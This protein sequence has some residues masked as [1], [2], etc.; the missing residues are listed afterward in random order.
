MKFYVNE[1]LYDA[2][3]PRRGRWDVQLK[4]PRDRLETETFETEATTL[5]TGAGLE[6][7]HR[8][9]G[10]RRRLIKGCTIRHYLYMSC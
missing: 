2:E 10:T 9:T 1:T 6:S 5:L 7:K 3:R 4:T 8:P